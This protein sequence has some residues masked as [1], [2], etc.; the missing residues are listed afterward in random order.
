MNVLS[1]TK[2]WLLPFVAT[3]IWGCSSPPPANESNSGSKLTIQTQ[4]VK[5]GNITDTINM[6]GQVALRQEAWLASQFEGRLEGFS[7]LK[8]DKVSKGQ[9]ACIIIPAVKEAL[10]QAIDSIPAEFRPLLEQEEKSIPLFCP[11]SGTVLDVLLHTGDVVAKGSH[12]AHIGDLRVLDVQAELPVTYLGAAK[13]AKRL[14]IEFTNYPSPT[15]ELPIEAFTGNVSKDQSLI[16]R[17]KLDNPSLNYRPGMRVKISFPAP[18]HENALLVPRQALVEE[19]GKYFLFVIENDVALKQPVTVGIMQNEVVEII[20][21]VKENQKVAIEKA[22]SLK[23][24]MEVIA[25]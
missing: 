18:V 16:V 23:D 25:R 11:I 4:P 17:L 8:G 14:R 1:K 12:I 6:Y 24:Q 21:G 10:L 7:M 15:L 2:I 3:W 20:K 9:L 13:K 19:E 5:I 22:Y